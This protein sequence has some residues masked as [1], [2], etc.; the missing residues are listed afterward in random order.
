[1]QDLLH[2]IIESITGSTDFEITVD[3]NET[4]Y[5]NM[6]V[7]ADPSIIGIII[8]KEGKIVKAIRNILKVRAIID[9]KAV[10]LRV[11]EKTS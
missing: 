1:M 8:G 7:L 4:G 9:K 2:Y 5:V 3:E 6:T 11:E 10:T